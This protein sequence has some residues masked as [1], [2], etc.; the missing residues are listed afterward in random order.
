LTVNKQVKQV[1]API[2]ATSIDDILGTGA[3][4]LS[5][6]NVTDKQK[7]AVVPGAFLGSIA[8]MRADRDR[9]RGRYLAP[10]LWSHSAQEPVGGFLEMREDKFGLYVEFEIDLLTEIGRRAYSA[11]KKQYVGGLSIGY[12]INKAQMRADGVRLLLDLDLLEGSVVVFPSNDQAVVFPGSMKHEPTEDEAIGALVQ[13]M[14]T[15]VDNYKKRYGAKPPERIMDMNMD[16]VKIHTTRQYGMRRATQELDLPER[17]VRVWY[18]EA[19]SKGELSRANGNGTWSMSGYEL[20]RKCYEHSNEIF[21]Q[22]VA[23]GRLHEGVL[24][25]TH[26]DNRVINAAFLAGI[27]E[28]TRQDLRADRQWPDSD[29]DESKFR[30]VT[31]EEVKAKAKSEHK[32]ADTRFAMDG[33]DD[34][35]LQR[36][37]LDTRDME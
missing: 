23:Q 37:L 17:I 25:V 32:S 26:E 7:D 27:P 12:R 22:W 33:R 1:V 10:M 15:T 11:L 35:G 13:T 2:E 28:A 3:G 30:T 20:S 9:R 6:F 31:D 19:A 8:R 16:K 34:D 5:V 29:Y 18:D 24:L 14:R 4:Y 21:G 36:P